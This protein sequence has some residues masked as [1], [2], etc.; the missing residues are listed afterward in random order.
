MPVGWDV[1]GPRVR[2]NL[3][4]K[5]RIRPFRESNPDRIACNLAVTARMV[6]LSAFVILLY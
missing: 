3:M 1:L 2:S 6:Q 5:R 4:A